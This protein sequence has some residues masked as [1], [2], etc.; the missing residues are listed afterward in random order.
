MRWVP[1]RRFGTAVEVA[2]KTRCALAPLPVV[3]VVMPT[4]LADGKPTSLWVPRTT[5]I[6]CSPPN[7]SR[8]PPFPRAAVVLLV[9]TKAKVMPSPPTLP[10]RLAWK[11]TRSPLLASGW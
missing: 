11:V 2:R 5:A 3:P 10:D 6:P 7:P 4:K 1:F 8:P 9:L